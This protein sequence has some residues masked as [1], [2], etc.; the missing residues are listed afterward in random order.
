LECSGNGPSEDSEEVGLGGDMT[1]GAGLRD[2]WFLLRSDGEPTGLD[3][4]LAKS[5]TDKSAKLLPSAISHSESAEPSSLSCVLTPCNNFI[6]S[7]QFCQWQGSEFLLIQVTILS[8]S[9]QTLVKKQGQGDG[10]PEPF[11]IWLYITI[12]LEQLII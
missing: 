9:I 10:D 4:P 1:L 7:I 3:D 11:K 8:M 2:G 5:A 12:I 6:C